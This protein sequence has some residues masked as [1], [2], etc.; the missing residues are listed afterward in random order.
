MPIDRTLAQ[1][2]ISAAEVDDDRVFTSRGRLARGDQALLQV[3]RADQVGLVETCDGRG[4]I[5]WCRGDCLSIG[6]QPRRTGAGSDNLK[7]IVVVDVV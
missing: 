4:H 3:E 5:I 7:R 6:A 1:H 2:R